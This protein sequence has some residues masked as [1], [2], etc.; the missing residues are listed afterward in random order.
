MLLKNEQGGYA[1]LPWG[2]AF[3]SVGV[4]ALPGM[5]IERAVFPAPRPLPDGF[6]DVAR[7]LE[8]RGRPTTALCGFELRVP[9]RLSV[10]EFFAFNDRHY[11]P[12]L[13]DWGV[14]RAAVSPATRTNVAPVAN[15][16]AGP[17]VL[18]FS[19]T[20]PGDASSPAFVL[21]GVPELFPGSVRPEDVVRAGEISDDALA[22]K[23]RNVVD[24]A[25]GNIGDL[26]AVWDD[27]C[28]VHVYSAHAI[29]DPFRRELLARNVAP[30]HGIVWH[31]AAPPTTNLEVE[32][33]V[34]RYST[35][36][37]VSS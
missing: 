4:V 36:V 22:E 30:A 7:Y 8:Q 24:V 21:S 35:E 37:T 2:L 12:R 20:V 31:A 16:P 26:G 34:R 14:V 9:A 17:A 23:L 15:G 32:V 19:Y 5:T 29:A 11:M 33:D 28:S 27:S 25:H 1:Y 18:A 10:D 3:A 6:D 13:T